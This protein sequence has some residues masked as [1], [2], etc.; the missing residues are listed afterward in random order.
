M[1]KPHRAP[2][3]VVDNVARSTVEQLVGRY[4]EAAERGDEAERLSVLR[5]M[6]EQRARSHRKSRRVG[7]EQD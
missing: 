5:E 3:L 4:R 7:H 6:A 1:T 2:R